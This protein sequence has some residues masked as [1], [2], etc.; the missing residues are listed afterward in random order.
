MILGMFIE[1][2]CDLNFIF[3]VHKNG[4]RLHKMRKENRL[5]SCLW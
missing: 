4:Q 5:P 3:L 2:V 1:G